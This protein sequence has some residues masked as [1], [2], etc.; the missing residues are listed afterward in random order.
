MKKIIEI[1]YLSKNALTPLCK[2]CGT[3]KKK[4]FQ[5]PIKHSYSLTTKSNAGRALMAMNKTMLSLKKTSYHLRQ[6]TV[7]H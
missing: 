1:Y 7:L 3:R 4:T 2:K 6:R 5:Y